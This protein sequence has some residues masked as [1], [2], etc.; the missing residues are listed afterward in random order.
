MDSN[1]I[2]YKKGE[3]HPELTQATCDYL[4]SCFSEVDEELKEILDKMK[5]KRKITV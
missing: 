1:I 5:R 2:K 4:D 3:K